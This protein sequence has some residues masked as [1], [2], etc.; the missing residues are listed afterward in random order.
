MPYCSCGRYYISPAP[1]VCGKC[2][3]PIIGGCAEGDR[4]RVTNSVNRVR[5]VVEIGGMRIEFLNRG[6]TGNVMRAR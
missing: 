5:D 6:N 2:G 4:F 3:T 1:T